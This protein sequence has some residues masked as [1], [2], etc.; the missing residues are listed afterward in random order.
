MK[1]TRVLLRTAKEGAVSYATVWLPDTEVQE[2]LADKSSPFF[3]K[4]DD[5]KTPYVIESIFSSDTLSQIERT[6]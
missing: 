2:R 5:D 6:N 3:I 4:N 1:M